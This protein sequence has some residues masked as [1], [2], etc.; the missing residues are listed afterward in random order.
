MTDTVTQPGV[1]RTIP[2]PD[3]QRGPAKD[4]VECWGEG[5]FVR[6][7]CPLCGNVGWDYINGADDGGGMV[8]ASAAATSGPATTRAGAP[9]HFPMPPGND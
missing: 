7:A 5:R 8:A 3:R 9:R 6:R 2:S 4:C 1:A